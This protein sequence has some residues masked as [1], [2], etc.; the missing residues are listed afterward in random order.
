MMDLSFC[1]SCGGY[2]HPAE[3]RLGPDGLTC[4]PCERLQGL[5]GTPRQ[6][7]TP[8]TRHEVQG[9]GRIYLIY[10]EIESAG[11]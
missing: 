4:G 2:V 3:G 10:L 7:T 1:Q 9:T 11:K 6:G 5:A 8:P